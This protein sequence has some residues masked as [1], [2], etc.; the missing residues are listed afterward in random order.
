MKKLIYSHLVL[1]YVRYGKIRTIFWNIFIFYWNFFNF[2]SNF[3][4]LFCFVISTN[5]T[6]FLDHWKSLCGPRLFAT[7]IRLWPQPKSVSRAIL[8]RLSRYFL[9]NCIFMLRFESRCTVFSL[10]HRNINQ[11]DHF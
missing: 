4:V 10:S 5:S 9:Q 1:F 7:N 8:Q 3:F 11:N 6:S 2:L